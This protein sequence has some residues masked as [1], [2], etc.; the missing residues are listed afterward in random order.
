MLHP[1]AELGQHR[2]RNVQR[3]L[4]HEINAHALGA[5]QPHHQLDALDQRLGCIG[6]QQM[7]F[8]KEKHQLGLVRVAD[9]GQLLEQLRQ[10]PQQEGGVQAR[11]MHQ[12]VGRQDV[13][14]AMP[15]AV[16]LHEVADVEHRLAKEFVAALGF[17]LHQSA[18]DGAHAG[19]ADIAVLGGELAGVVPHMLQHGAK[20]LQIKQQQAVVVGNLEDQVQDAGLR[21][22][23]V[24]HAAQQQRPHVGHGGTHRM[25]LLAEHIPQR[26]RAGQGFG[27][28]Q[29]ALLQDARQFFPHDACLADAGQ[30]AFHIGHEDRHADSGKAF[31]QGLQRDGFAGSRGAGDQAVS[32]GQR[33]QQLAL[34]LGIFSNKERLGH[35]VEVLMKLAW[36]KAKRKVK[37]KL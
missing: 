29:A 15:R 1:V 6:E 31:S 34:R 35:G 8:V 2:I 18:L 13:D 24:E 19:G 30:V 14:D 20:V 33:R 16:G 26:G 7:G 22:I 17:D 3:V 10:H 21:F 36:A 23:Q 27:Q 9:F 4:R 28:P 37:W 11:R 25:A 5:H 12:L 32:V